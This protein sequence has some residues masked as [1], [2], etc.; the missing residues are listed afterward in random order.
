[1]ETNTFTPTSLTT[2]HP[3]RI[4][5]VGGG[6]V[7]FTLARCLERRLRRGEAEVVLVDASP[8][9]TY[10]PFLAETAA[11]SIEPRHVTV[12]LRSTLRR[13]R[14][15]TGR[16]TDASLD[17]RQ[18]HV[19]LPDGTFTSQGYDELVLAPG[20]VTRSQPVPGLAE[21]AVG[22]T[23]LGDARRL[24]D[25]VLTR[26]ALA[27]DLR[28]PQRRRS[29]LTFVVIGGG[30]S[31]VEAV[32]ELQHLAVAAARRYPGLTP[33]RLRFVL[34]EAA[35]EILPELPPELGAYARRRLEDSGVRVRRRTQVRSVAGGV[36]VLSDGERFGADTIVW[37]AGVRANPVLGRLGLATDPRGRLVTR[38]TLQVTGVSHVWAAGDGAAVPD[39]SRTPTDEDPAPMCGA[40][41][42]HAVRQA[43]VLAD[44]LAATIRGGALCE[45]RHRDAGT[46][47]SLGL[48]RGVARIY[49]VPLR[50]L[51]AWLVH[52]VY[53]L[54]M[55]PTWGRK[56]RV[57]LDWAAALLG[58]RD[59]STPDLTGDAGLAYDA[60]QQWTGARA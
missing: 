36:V 20:S 10:Q 34:V 47:A 59:L 53:H 4:V 37:A 33:G 6:F 8:S 26:L 22:F 38:A 2:K 24:R 25:A 7:G 11:G 32:A 18:V 45:Y 13:T 27:A 46:V 1:M 19:A 50:G 42:Q 48:H 56:V 9:M 17:T 39:L 23:S 55:I 60:P 30:Y 21:H 16:V 40:T 31:G 54:A 52:R 49:G 28:E 3:P 58:R 41:A 29:A 43:R 57:A 5:I 15:V 51:P 14:V 35:D 44:N 12:P